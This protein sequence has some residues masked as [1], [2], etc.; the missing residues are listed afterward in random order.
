MA[1]HKMPALVVLAEEGETK[2]KRAFWLRF[3]KI[4]PSALPKERL[5]KLKDL[6]TKE[7]LSQIPDKKDEID[8]DGDYWQKIRE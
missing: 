5:Y 1:A 7:G 6:K 4:V 8:S 2:A 3:K